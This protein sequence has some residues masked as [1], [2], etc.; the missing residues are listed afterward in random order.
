M[1][2][3]VISRKYYFVVKFFTLEAT[4]VKFFKSQT[5]MQEVKIDTKFFH[6]HILH[7]PNFHKKMSSGLP[8]KY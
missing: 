2:L 8:M 1:L 4:K 3:H 6:S 7:W 5:F